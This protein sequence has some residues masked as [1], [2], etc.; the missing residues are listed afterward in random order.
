MMDDME[1]LHPGCMVASITYQERMF[2]ADVRQMNVDYLLRMR[3]RFAAWLAQIA[4]ER[5]TPADVDLEGLADQLTTIVEGAI[6]LSKALNDQ[7][8]MGRQTR[9]FRNHVKLVFGA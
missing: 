2:D 1:T 9:L 4:A 3:R 6:I 8:L 5:P 7:G